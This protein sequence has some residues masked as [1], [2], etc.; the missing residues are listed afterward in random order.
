M[1]PKPC[2]RLLGVFAAALLSAANLGC[3]GASATPPP[4][5]PV[6]LSLDN[7]SAMVEESA[8]QPFTATVVND[9][10]AA[11]VKWTVSCSANV[12]GTVTPGATASGVATTYTAPGPPASDLTVTLKATSV[13]DPT[14]STSATI[15]VPALSVSLSTTSSTVQ[16]AAM[17]AINGTVNNDPTGG[18]LN[19]SLLE[20]GAACSPG[21]GTLAPASGTSTTYTAPTTPPNS[22][23]TVTVTG[24]SATDTTKSASA[25][26]L[27]PSVG[28]TVAPSSPTVLATQNTGLTA[29]LV[30]D[31]SNAG[32]NWT[33]SCPTAPCG[34]VSKSMTLS[35]IA[36]NYT[37][38]VPP[39]DVQVTVTATSIA[40]SNAV[41]TA[42]VN[43][44]AIVVSVVQPASGIIPINGKPSFTATVSN[45]FTNELNWTVTQNGTDCSPACGTMNPGSTLSQ[46]S[47]VLNGPATLP[48]NPS[49]SVNAVSKTD[50]TKFNSAAI[51]LTNGT[52]QLIPAELNFSCKLNSTLNPCPPPAQSV[53]LTNTGAAALPITSIA[54]TGPFSVTHN[55]GSS[56]AVAG[57][58][59]ISVTFTSKLVGTHSGT[60]VLTDGSSDS[61]QQVSLQ[62]RVFQFR[63]AVQAKADL[64]VTNSAAVPVPTGNN[65]VGTRVLQLV[66]A[67]RQDPYV[68]NGGARQLAIRVWYPVSSHSNELCKPSEYT[69]PKV[70]TYFAQ[71][72][73][74][75]PFPVTTN[76]CLGAPLAEGAHPVV[77]LT[78][79]YT[80]TSSDYT[81]LTEEL[82]SR[83]YVVM[84]VNHTYEATAVEFPDGRLVKSHVGSHLGGPLPRDHGSL[85]SALEAR[86]K[87][88][89]FV[90]GEIAL[91]NSR[92]GS[93]FEGRLDLTKVA[94]AGHSLGGL[95]A[96]LAGI[97][98]PRIKAMI[99]M[100]SVLPDVLPGRTSKPVLM[101][102]ADRTQWATNECELWK[103]L[104]GPRMAVSLQGTEHVALSDWIW[105][106]KDA[107]K[108][109]SM[110]PQ[111]TMSALR[112]YIGSFL[113]ANLRGE[114]ANA[115]LT[116]PSATYP[117]AKVFT[118]DQGLCGMR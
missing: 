16:V 76:S 32:V 105:L 88:L 47:S 44:P 65:V 104:N 114:P 93:P 51:T 108:T 24:T 71:L 23:M 49:V 100:D 37:A 53:A 117:D 10:N 89:K 106:T 50:P 8:A 94:V 109:G 68:A 43:V 22:N 7:T 66:D 115:L 101:L 35:G 85:A 1:S 81:F 79:G 112:D 62:G 74:V 36:T 14:K 12:C 72:V 61:P 46:G 57:T 25:T 96:L 38:T 111:K 19:W 9:A 60:L 92:R 82:A 56:V 39:N 31:K 99:L 52:V 41:A 63:P 75:A 15:T 98:D 40:N 26:L 90:L 67:S 95:T 42:L 84:A 78:P 87:D 28:I 86:E 5:L 27:V 58:C 80:G 11:G 18:N 77:L 2:T 73:G 45:D 69:S 118:H 113:D 34:D 30:N 4:P 33:V 55:C 102:A 59:S 54:T 91:L 48:A 20:N 116:G 13:A 6:S 83:G 17:F 70:W 21:C 107:V 3:G 64:A 110:G 103:D 29:T 97:E